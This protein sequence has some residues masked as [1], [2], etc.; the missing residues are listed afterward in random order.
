MTGILKEQGTTMKH[1]IED[2]VD[3]CSGVVEI[4]NRI[5]V[6]GPNYQGSSPTSATSP[7]TRPSTKQ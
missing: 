5:R 6:A 2:M 4:D 7:T 1:A 3:D